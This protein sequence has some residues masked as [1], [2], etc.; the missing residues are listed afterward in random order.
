MTKKIVDAFDSANEVQSN[1]V[2]FNV[3]GED[4]ILGTLIAVR[5]MKSSIPGHEGEMV[6]VYD[7]KADY[8]SFH[9]LDDNKV[10]VPEPIIVNKDEIWSIGGKDIIDR[11]MTNVKIG[12]VIGF[13]FT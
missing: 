9:I 11:Q 3:V 2:K 8:G 1:W 6:K 4:K 10:L 7:L 13:K 12:Q 5:T